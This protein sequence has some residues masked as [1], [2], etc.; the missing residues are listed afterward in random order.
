MIKHLSLKNFT[1]FKDLKFSFSPSINIIIGESGT[2]KTHILKSIDSLAKI[3]NYDEVRENDPI[4]EVRYNT[5]SLLH[6]FDPHCNLIDL[7][8]NKLLKTSKLA[9]DLYNKDSVKASIGGDSSYIDVKKVVKSKNHL[10]VFIPSKE[11]MFFLP[12]FVGL[13][14]KFELW[15]DLNHQNIA[16]DIILPNRKKEQ[17]HDTS[18]ELI[19]DIK[20]LLG[21]TFKVEADLSMTFHENGDVR[22]AKLMAE[23]YRKFGVLSRLIESG[24]I[25][26][27]NSG[28]LLWDEPETNLNPKLM[29][30]LVEI[31][32]KLSQTGQQIILVT[33]SYVFMKWF[34][35]LLDGNDDGIILYH[36]LNRDKTSLEVKVETYENYLDIES[37]SIDSAYEAILNTQLL[38]DMEKY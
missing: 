13:T 19:K 4:H 31:L 26:P 24:C 34:E 11:M 5:L 27:G 37:N 38:K 14:N 2:G 8:N 28:P 30:A 10:P 12:E 9:M 18:N 6:T 7:F 22:P 25:F 20:T 15:T 21:G 3:L 16:T 36:N 35:L 1:V 33:H 32:I 29:R 17:L 23:G